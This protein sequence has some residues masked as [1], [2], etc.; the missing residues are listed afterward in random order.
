MRPKMVNYG[1]ALSEA[2]INIYDPK[3]GKVK[4]IDKS[5]GLSNNNVVG[6]LTDDQG[7]RWAATYFGI[8]VLSKEGQ[9]L[10]H[11]FENEGLSDNEF[12]R[13]SYLEAYDGKLLF[14]TIRGLNLLH[15]KELK[16]ELLTSERFQVYLTGISYFDIETKQSIEQSHSLDQLN[17]ITLPASKRYVE[18][19]FA[20]SSY[21]NADKNTFIYKIERIAEVAEIPDYED[22]DKYWD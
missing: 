6:I 15:P 12:N 14:G 18:L 10:T 22:L 11:L 9:V 7:D 19:K 16:K 20:S 21:P 2:V 5:K 1:L 13:T 17:R 3:S 8:N 4:I